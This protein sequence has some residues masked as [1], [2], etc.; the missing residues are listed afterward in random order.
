M[1]IKVD[2][3]G[4]PTRRIWGGQNQAR[5]IQGR[6]EGLPVAG[7]PGIHG[8]PPSKVPPQEVC[9]NQGDLS[10]AGT[11]TRPLRD[12]IPSPARP[13]SAS[14]SPTR[15]P[16][17]SVRLKG[18]VHVWAGRGRGPACS[19]GKGLPVYR[20][21]WRLRTE[22]PRPHELEH[23]LQDPQGVHSP[24][25]Y[26]MAERR[27]SQESWNLPPHPHSHVISGLLTPLPEQHPSNH[28]S[29]ESTARTEGAGRGGV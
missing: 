12:P 18:T 7:T 11:P 22:T 25:P 28:S 4:K 6:C 13:P 29:E 5:G 3:P 20:T 10:V 9:K 21:Q 15:I 14:T 19:G 27:I 24:G 16:A 26:L 2:R 1:K 8:C 17:G 23:L